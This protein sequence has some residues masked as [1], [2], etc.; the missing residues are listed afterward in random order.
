M[1]SLAGRV[2]T[3]AVG[4]TAVLVVAGLF[5]P[6]AS[7]T[8]YP[9]TQVQSVVIPVSA[10]EAIS[11]VSLTGS[12]PARIVAVTL[13]GEQT[14]AVSSPIT[15]PK[16]KAKGVAQFTNLSQS[17]VIIPAGTVV[18]APG[19]TTVRFVTLQE[20]RIPAEPG[21]FVDAPV[22]AVAPGTTGNV[23][24]GAINT[25]EGLLGLSLSVT[26]P[27]PTSGGTELKTAGPSENDRAR[28]RNILLDD[29]RQQA[30]SRIRA[31]LAEGDILFTDT[32]DVSQIARETFSPP[33]GQPGRQ[34]T[35]SMEV[36]FAARTASADDLN[37]LASAALDASRPAGY[38]TFFLPALEPVK[39]PVTDSQGVTSLEL[40][41]SRTLHREVRFADVFALV[42]GQRPAA[43][44]N[45]LAEHI[46]SREPP[47]IVLTP[48]WWPWLPLIPFN[49]SVVEK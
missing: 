30:A 34:L 24:A 16:T 36:E 25:L 49:L 5:I 20:T 37:Q 35:L 19:E 9:E 26:N 7:V 42:R 10:S 14:L 8:L 29:L 31:E 33:A 2:A 12:V 46:P 18:I 13:E 28:L 17:E 48:G 11:T 32:L 41:A 23:D 43:A 15:I 39:Q 6:R 1:T 3:F 21:Q 4:V 27:E 44:E 47:E 40:K 22:E 38:Q 45:A